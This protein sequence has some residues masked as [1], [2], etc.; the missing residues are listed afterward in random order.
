MNTTDWLPT[1]TDVAALLRARTKDDTGRELG[2]WSDATRP[3]AQE[4][5]V[6]IAQA[7]SFVAASVGGVPD[8]CSDAAAQATLLR[9]A[10]LVELSYFPEQVRSDRSPYPELKELSD[11]ALQGAMT[12]V[13]SGGESGGGAGGEGYS[14]HSLPVVPAT[15]ADSIGWRHP[16]YP[17]TWQLACVPPTPA[18]PALIDEPDTAD[19]YVPDIVIGYPPF[20][21]APPSLDSLDSEVLLEDLVTR[22]A[23]FVEAM[24]RPL[25]H[26]V[27]TS[28]IAPD[29]DYPPSWVGP[30]AGGFALRDF[31][32]AVQELG[33]ITIADPV[34]P[35]DPNF[36]ATFW[37]RVVGAPA[38]LDQYTV[39]AGKLTDTFYPTTVS[40]VATPKTAAV[41][42]DGFFS[43]DVQGVDAQPGPWAVR[44]KDGAGDQVGD[45]WPSHATLTGVEVQQHVSTDSDYLVA[46]QP[47]RADGRTPSRPAS[48]ATEPT[49][50]TSATRTTKP[51]RRSRCSPSGVSRQRASSCAACCGCSTAARR[52]MAASTSPACSS[53][54]RRAMHR[55]ALAHTRWRHTRCCA[56][57]RRRPTTRRTTTSAPRI[58]RWR[59]CSPTSPPTLTRS[60]GCTRA[61]PRPTRHRP[62]S[63][64]RRPSTTSTRGTS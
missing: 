18:V 14:Y 45:Y 12:C 43:L 38:P 46:S 23:N 25:R 57:W 19:P 22:S 9:A 48:R 59:S 10:M 62:K 42:T 4:V 30:V 60:P 63:A 34:Q 1:P 51:S 7:A 56:T 29:H 37:G 6:L 32:P 16:E 28:T 50:S 64:G 2:D 20:P 26:P 41:D 33:Y 49:S 3:T 8:R 35:V 40:G 47:A 55:S 53:R 5:D 24:M 52:T 27:T 39:E 17:E 11:L 44:L 61:A 15:L 13:T 58:A 21:P 54:P 31:A 36:K